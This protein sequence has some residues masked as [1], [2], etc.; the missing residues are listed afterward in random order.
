MSHF[1]LFLLAVDEYEQ[2]M[3]I[4]K[5]KRYFLNEKLKKVFVIRLEIDSEETRDLIRVILSSNFFLMRLKYLFCI[6]R[7]MTLCLKKKCVSSLLIW[8][9]SLGN[10]PVVLY[11]T[12]LVIMC[13]SLVCSVT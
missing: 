6:R 3:N 10:E 4:P 8:N 5:W 13:L 1:P 2:G 12:G 11:E 9:R 7:G